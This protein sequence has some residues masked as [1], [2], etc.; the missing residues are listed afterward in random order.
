MYVVEIPTFK[1]PKSQSRRKSNVAEF[2]AQAR[3]RSDGWNFGGTQL[4]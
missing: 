4:D 2:G 3:W 1:N